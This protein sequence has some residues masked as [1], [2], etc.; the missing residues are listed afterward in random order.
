MPREKKAPELAAPRPEFTTVGD[1]IYR[2]E[3]LLT[4]T[5]GQP[6]TLATGLEVIPKQPRRPV[7]KAT[8]R[9]KKPRAK[10]TP[11]PKAKPVGPAPF[12][13]TIYH[14]RNWA[15]AQLPHWHTGWKPTSTVP[16]SW[17]WLEFTHE[18]SHIY[19]AQPLGKSIARISRV[20]LGKMITNLMEFCQANNL[21]YKEVL[22]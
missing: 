12:E 13:V 6:G 1:A 15:Y 14:V 21:E 19:L 5:A 16:S 3:Y 9:V 7:A 18:G 11:A 8:E 4:E 20:H 22:C 17:G 10:P 2:V